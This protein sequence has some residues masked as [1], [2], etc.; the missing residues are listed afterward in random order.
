[1]RLLAADSEAF[2]PAWPSP[3]PHGFA[4][5]CAQQALARKWHDEQWRAFLRLPS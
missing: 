5:L 4:F 1:M 3:W 2:P